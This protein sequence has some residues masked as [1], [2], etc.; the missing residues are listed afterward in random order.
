MTFG[1]VSARSL[2]G[3]RT[4]M[5]SS[6]SLGA[7]A[8]CP[9]PPPFPFK[10]AGA[11]LITNKPIVDAHAHVFNL[12]DLP[13]FPF[14]H[15]C[16]VERYAGL[17]LEGLVPILKAIVNYVQDA[18]PGYEE[19]LAALPHPRP[20]HLR[21]SAQEA[22]THALTVTANGDARQNMHRALLPVPRI[23]SKAQQT[24]IFAGLKDVHPQARNLDDA[25]AARTLAQ[26]MLS[27]QPSAGGRAA[28]KKIFAGSHSDFA[29]MVEWVCD[30]SKYRKEMVQDWQATIGGSGPRF[31]MASLIDFNYSLHDETNTPVRIWD[32]VAL[33]GEISRNLPAGL[34][35]HGYVAFNPVRY[36]DPQNTGLVRQMIE[37]A[38]ERQGFLGAKLYPPMGFQAMDN[39]SLSMSM[40]NVPDFPVTGAKMDEALNWLYDYILS[41]DATI[42][43][44]TSPTNTPHAYPYDGVGTDQTQAN[45]WSVRPDPKFWRNVLSNNRKE[46]RV[47][48][49]HFGGAFD[50][51]HNKGWADEVVGLMK[52]FPN[53][54]ADFADDS[55]VLANSDVQQ[56]DK[57][58]LGDYLA[59]LKSDEKALLSKRVMF[60]TDWNLMGRTPNHELYTQKM[61]GF[62][63]DTLG[64]DPD[65]FACR[66][67]LRFAGFDKPDSKAL[68]RLNDFHARN[69]PARGTLQ[70]FVR[71]VQPVA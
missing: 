47:N 46:M 70:Q 50:I 2:L 69:R 19:E 8:C 32:Q 24:Q 16:Y 66:N 20:R 56:R 5:A 65:D 63:R 58:A 13:A 61:L 9:T 57:D 25:S 11:E 35:V 18:A 48:I 17:L 51:C 4:F 27:G 52:E 37:D 42:L 39:A 12:K 33:M 49:G 68:E 34:L 6:A 15:E 3:R 40:F 14:I 36:M 62:L 60:G 29:Q 21:H 1:R 64:G 67:A 38:I 31:C 23:P 59:G 71:L 43:A 22:L 10:D 26:D 44:H 45:N 54:Y 7:A 41:K 53:V 55:E 28:L 30:Y